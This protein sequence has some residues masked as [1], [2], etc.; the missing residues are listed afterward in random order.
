[1]HEIFKFLF[2]YYAF[3]INNGKKL[4][5]TENKAEH[6]VQ[7]NAAG[8]S[9]IILLSDAEQCYIMLMSSDYL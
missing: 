6:A 5:P 3:G 9:C 4:F 2:F 8:K 1:M 7:S